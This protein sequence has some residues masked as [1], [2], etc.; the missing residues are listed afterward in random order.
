[1]DFEKAFDSLARDVSWQVMKIYTVPKT[2]VNMMKGLYEGFKC[3]VVHEGKLT[4]SF[5][6]TTRVRHGCI[7]SPDPISCSARQCHEQD[8]DF[9]DDIC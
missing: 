1:V 2:I 9:A 8:L 4:D 3:R 7:L 5:E 6:V